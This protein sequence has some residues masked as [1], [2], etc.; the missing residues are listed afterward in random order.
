MNQGYEGSYALCKLGLQIWCS[1]EGVYRDTIGVET[2]M[3]VVEPKANVYW[4]GLE[5]GIDFF[6]LI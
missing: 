2:Q 4:I 1:S 5:V 3:M 6:F